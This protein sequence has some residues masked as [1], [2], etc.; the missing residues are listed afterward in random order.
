M[1]D[2]GEPQRRALWFLSTLLSQKV[3]EKSDAVLRCI[4]SGQPKPEVTWYKN[5]HTIDECGSVCSYESFE[6]QYVHELHLC[7]C[8][9]N[10]TAVYQVSAQNCFGMICCSAS[11]EVQSPSGDRPLSPNPK[12][13]GHTGWKHDTETCEQESP[14]RTDEKE[15]PYKEGEGVASGPPTSADAPSSKSD[16]ACSLQVSADRDPGASGSE[17]PLEVKD[18]RQTEEAGD[19]A[20]TEGVAGGLRFPNSSDAP[21]KQDVCG[22]RTVHSKVPRL[23]DGA[24][25]PEGPNEEALNSGHQHASVQKYLSLSLPLTQAGSSAPAAARPA[26]PLASSTGSDSDYELCPEITL[27]CAEEFSDDDLEYLECSDV[28]TDYSNA[29]WQRN[30]QHTGRVFLLESDDEEMEFS[31]CS[32]GGCEGFFSELGPRPPVSDDTGPMDA[33]AG[34]C[35]HHSPPQE[36]GGRSSR[37]S[38]RRAS[39]LQVGMPLPPGPQQDGRATVTDPGRYK[40]PAASEVAEDSYPGIQG[41]TRDSHQAGKE[42]P[43]DNLLN[44]DKV[45]TET[46]GT[47]LSGESGQ[48]GMSLCLETTTRK[49]V[50][51]EDV[52]SRRG[53]EKPARTWQPGIKGKAKRL[54]SSLEERTAEASLNRLCP[55]GPVKHPLTPSDKRDSS[56]AR[57]EGTDLKP[58]FPAG[59]RAV[60]TQAEPEAKTLQTPPGSLSKKENLHFQGEGPWVTDVFETSKVSGWSDH[61][62]VQIQETFRERICLSH[63][64]AF[65]EPTGEESA[66]PGTTTESLPNLGGIDKE[67]ASLAEHLEVEG[68]TQGA[69]REEK[70]DDS[71]LGRPW[72]DLGRALSIPEAH[73]EAT[74]PCELSGSPSQPRAAPVFPGLAHTVPALETVCAGPGNGVAACGTERLKAGDQEA[75]DT[76]GS[77]V[78]APV[79]KYLPQ[80]I[81][82]LDLELAGQSKPPDLCPPDDKTLDVL[83]QTRGPEPPQTTC[84]NSDERASPDSPLFISNFIWNISQKASKGATREN[85]ANVEGST[86]TPASTVKAGRER[87]SPSHPGGL[88]ERR[89]LSPESNSSVCAREGGDEN[90]SPG[91]LDSA[92]ILAG[93]SSA[94]KFPQE[95]PTTLIANVECSEVTGEKDTCALSVAPTGHPPRYLAVSVA[96]DSHAGGPEESSPR[97]PGGNTSQL[98][99]NVPLAHVVNGSTINSWRE[100]GHVAPSGPGIHAQVPP[101]P[102]GEGFCSSSPLQIDNLSRKKSQTGPRADT[103]ALGENFQEKGSETTQSV[104]QGS[105]DDNFQEILPTTSVGQVETNLVPLGCSSASTERGRQNSGLGTCV[106]VMAESTA[107]DDSRPLSQGPPLANVLLDESKESSPGYWEAGKKLKIITLEASVSETWPLGQ[108][109]DSGLK[110][111]DAGVIPDRIRAIPDVLKAGAAVPKPGPSKTASACSPQAEDGSANANIRKIHKRE[112]RARRASWSCLSS[113]YLSQ[114]RFLESSVDPVEEKKVCVTGLLPEAFSTERKENAN[115]VSQNPD[116][117]RLERDR[118]AFFKQLLSRPNVLESSVDPIDEPSAGWAGVD[119]PEA[120]ESTLGAVGRESKPDD[121]PS[122]RRLEVQPAILQ[123]PCPQQ[124]GETPPSKNSI[125]QNQGD[126]VGREAGQS[127]RDGA[128]RDVR[129]A[130][131]PVPGPVRGGEAIPGGRLR[132]RLQEGGERR[133]G[134]PGR[135]ESNRAALVPPALA[136]SSGLA[137]MTPASVGVNTHSRTAQ[138]HDLREEDFVEPRHQQR[139]V[140]DSEERRAVKSARKRAPSSGLTRGPFTSSPE[141]GITGFSRSHRAEERKTEGPPTGET[142][143]TGTS[144]SPARPPAPVSGERVPAEVAKILLGPRPQGSTLGHAGK[145]GEKLGPGAAQASRPPPPAAMKSQEAKEKHKAPAS[146]HLPEGVKNKILSRVAALRLRLEEKENVRKHSAVKGPEPG[147]P[148]SRAAEEGEPQ[149]PPCQ[150]EGRAPVLLKKIQAEM[151]PDHS[152][153]VKLSCQF[154]EI[155]EDSTISWTKDSRSIAQVQRRAGDNSMVSLAILQAGQKDQGLYYCC[156]RNSYGKV[157]AEFNLTAEV[158]K[159]LSSHPDVKV[160]EEIEFSQLIFR[161]D[162]LRDSYFGGRLHGQI[163]T[164]ELHFG[165][166]VHRRAFRSKV[167]RGLTPVFKPGHA[168]VLKVHNAVAY[169]TRNNDELIQRN[170]RLAAQECYVQN[171]ARHYAQIYAAEAQPLEGFGEVPEIIP[172][173]L[174]HRPENNIPYATVEE[175]LIGEFVKYSIRDGK[176]INFLRRESEAGQ[177]CCTF[178]HWVYQK[179]SGCLLVTDM[180]GVGMKLTDVGIATEAKG[181]R[182]FKGNCSMTFIDQFKALHQCNKY[183]KMLGLKSLQ[184]NSQKQQQKPGIGRSKIQPSA[185]AA[186]KAAS[187][188][189]AAKKS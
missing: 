139:A 9:Q 154:A 75:C 73:S 132:S 69:Q 155:H 53:P 120:S 168:C 115:R 92:D 128:E 20:N 42:F 165:E 48:P 118:P 125:D 185:P 153:N 63:M 157:T 80:E 161:E 33:T 102:E 77:L 182:G 130:I 178:Q 25:A 84:G 3:P 108:P 51:G 38:M 57:A 179:T 97:A 15:H 59:G 21:G 174:I 70:Q 30:L 160:Y 68:C 61:P 171:T 56:H 145:L 101:L 166:G 49:R 169:G 1:A 88:E 62:Q 46:E 40:P 43:S 34:L 116:E 126:R 71:T 129:S 52:W 122:D 131:L 148:G 188:G 147:T 5:G 45:V 189:P 149:G 104:Q 17:N 100:L 81:C 170:Y 66:F 12:D 180:Q 141:R 41:E 10:D 2:S 95:K 105:S 91:A 87:L 140:S 19:A 82:S 137:R 176:E 4:I 109:T 72:G 134:G 127:H 133:S 167:L 98:P 89:P 50:G 26:S 159:Q 55:K 103:R 35:G 150:S 7:C 144:G 187:G 181:Y 83:P 183:C 29:I 107:K 27:T 94:A 22:H 186:K 136:L 158:L 93:H 79:G 6:N 152:G 106:P 78:G 74:S 18:T 172:I 36:V 86:S 65:S 32:L 156:I 142:E 96:G 184:D 39:S 162:F 64:P 138:S 11:V 13:D 54:N 58:Q 14:N 8:T 44:M 24:L 173:F 76:V 113:Q 90:A 99:S 175:E 146:G 60:P 16:G 31:E 23:I 123:V 112:D 37:A 119:P 67:S 47:R 28:M 117:N 163:A 135:S 143:P 121:G 151:S 111:M 177:K 124:S 110:G 114:R 164:E 85:L